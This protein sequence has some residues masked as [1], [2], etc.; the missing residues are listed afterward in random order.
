[1]KLSKSIILL[2]IF[3][4]HSKIIFGCDCAAFPTL[5]KDLFNS[6]NKKSVVFRGKVIN[7]GKCDKIAE[8][9]F[10]VQELFSG[11][12][13]KNLIALFDCESSCMMN[14]NNGEEW[15]IYGEYV[16][17]EKIKIEFCSRSRRIN[18]TTNNEAENLTFGLSSTDELNWLRNNIGT[19]IIRPNEEHRTAAHRNEQPKPTTKIILITCSI[20]A[21]VL[22]L[23]LSK[24]FF[25]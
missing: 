4:L 13:S 20:V 17:L 16:Q 22:F 7:M 11:N 19:K 23:I 24:R 9:T 1:M 15:I 18:S 14:F 3:F 21:M 12:A 2:F 5:S 6:V 10:E 25:K 8:C